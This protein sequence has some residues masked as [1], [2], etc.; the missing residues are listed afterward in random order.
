MDHA[1]EAVLRDDHGHAEV[2]DE[3]SHRRQD[4]FSCGRVERGRGLV[5]DEHPRLRGEHRADRDSLLLAAREAAQ[6]TRAQ[7]GDAEQIEGLL[8]ALAH[9]VGRE[10]DLLHRVRQLLLDGV[11]D[12]AREWVLAHVA[13]G[14]GH[15][16]GLVLSRVAPVDR[17]AT[18]EMPAG[19]VGDEPVDR[20]EQRRLARSCRTDDEAELALVD[21][22][23]DVAK[24]GAVAPGVRERADVES[25]HDPTSTG[26]RRRATSGAGATRSPAGSRGD[27]RRGGARSTRA[28][29]P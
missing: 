16:T 25:D 20:A 23:V 4:V 22:E 27:A 26:A 18:D 29:R 28:T 12:E 11:G 17:D 5:E 19:E 15:V 3:S 10:A 9:H 13:D 24:D 6:R 1:L 7:I 21:R 14:L 8:D 2:V